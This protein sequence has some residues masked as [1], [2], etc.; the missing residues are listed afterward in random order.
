M[1]RRN[2]LIANDGTNKH[3]GYEIREGGG[4]CSALGAYEIKCP[5]SLQVSFKLDT[6]DLS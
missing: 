5:L 4:E 1:K 3:G 6:C 2:V